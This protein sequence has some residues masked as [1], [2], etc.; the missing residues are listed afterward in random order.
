[1]IVEGNI[2]DIENRK[3]YAGS[4]H[5]LDGKI[6]SIEP[7]NHTYSNYIL[8]GF[9]DAHVHI[10]SSMLMPAAFAQEA[11]K[12]GTV[13]TI[14]DP[15]EIANVLG[16]EGI[17]FYIN[18]AKQTPFKVFFGAPSCVP[19]TGFE[20]AGAVIDA[21]QTATLMQS[22]DIWYLAEMMNFPGVIYDDAEVHKKIKSAHAVNKVVD[23]HAPGLRGEALTK[24]LAAGITT[25]HECFTYEEG[26][27]KAEHGI[28]ILIREGSAAKNYE[29]LI[30]LMKEFPKLIMF[31]SDDKHPDD[32]LLGH[33][34][35][36]VARAVA[37]GYDLFDVLHAACLAPIKHYSVPVG[38]LQEG[39]IA[40]M[41]VVN[42]LTDFDVHQTILNGEIVFENGVSKI[43]IPPTELPNNFNCNEKVVSDFQLHIQAENLRVIEAHDGQLI[44]TTYEHKQ[45]TTEYFSSDIEHDILQIAVINR[46]QDAPVANALIKGFGLKKGAIASTVAHDSHNIICV[47]TSAEEMCI[48]VNALVKS[49]GGIVVF[50]GSECD[51]L[52]LPIAGLISAHDTSYVAEKYSTLTQKT[53][54]LGSQLHSPFMT[55][56]FMALLVIPELKLS[57][58]GLFDGKTFQ[59]T[60]IDIS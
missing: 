54:A 4:I 14:S 38:M 52:P 48:A 43:Q 39:S 36:L 9:I 57:D 30:P 53:K 50:D 58:K 26:K 18:N 29:A 21:E 25:D 1:M 13:A 32:L 37:D 49:K 42:N 34:N 12:H 51:L 17:Q 5:L 60:S 56:S 16:V 46:Y 6:L 19:A 35:Q 31:C 2:V 7:N 40:D 20:T 27:E 45:S 11:V 28:K 47:G 24:Y 8:P 59:F 23:G 15:H 33:I 55:L 10:E 22:N 3:I 41:I 44:T